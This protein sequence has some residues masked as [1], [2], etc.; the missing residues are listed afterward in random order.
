[1]EQRLAL[2]GNVALAGAAI[3]LIASA[4]LGLWALVSERRGR[5]GQGAWP[6]WLH[7][8]AW[9]L[10]SAAMGLLIGLFLTDA[11]AFAYVAGR[12]SRALATVYKVAALWAGQEG[13]LVLWLWLQ[14]GYGLVVAWRAHEGRTLD[15]GAA[16][17][18]AAISAFFAVLVAWVL[19][20]F[21]LRL[22]APADGA[23]M[24]PILQ[25]YWMTS[26]PVMLYLGYVG[27]SVPFAYALSSLVTGDRAWIRI[28]R[29]WSLV[30]WAFLS[31]GILYGARWAYEVLGWG[32]YWGWDPVE[33]ASF[34]PWLAATAFI[35]SGI[36][37]EKRGMLRRWNYVLV[38]VTYLLTVFGT[39]VTR[40][41][42]LSSVHAFV[43]SD[44]SPWFIG[45]MGVFIAAFLYAIIA[46]WPELADERPIVSPLSKESSFLAGNV[47]LLATCFAIFWGTIFPLVAAAFGRQV[48]VGTPY[49]E[50]VTGPLFWALIVLMGVGPLIAWRKATAENLKRQF[51]APLVNAFFMLI[52]LLVIGVRELPV[53]MALPAVMFVAITIVME[54]AKGVSTRRKS[55][56]EP[57]LV[58]LVR[59]MNRSPGRYG[60]Y[61]VHFGVLM[62]V[63]GVAL[64]QV[65]Q[66]ETNAVLQVGEQVAIGPYRLSLFHVDEA[67]HGGVPAVEAT[68]LVR[69]QRSRPLGYILPSK[70]FYPTADPG[71]GPTT[72]AAIYGTWKGD[73]YAVLAG[74]EPYGTYVGLKLYYSPGVWLIWTGGGLLV[75]GTLFSLWPRRRA[76]QVSEEERAVASLAELELD[77][78]A[79]KVSEAEYRA[80]FAEL[81]PKARAQLE[82]EKQ[83][84]ERVLAELRMRVA[85]AE[86]DGG[87]GSNAGE[88]DRARGKIRSGNEEAGDGKD[89]PAGR[90]RRGGYGRASSAGKGV[91]A[92]TES[93][94]GTAQG[95]R[96]GTGTETG[97]ESGA[98]RG[99]APGTGTGTGTGLIALALAA[100]LAAFSLGDVAFA[101]EQVPPGTSA[102]G[103]DTEGSIRSAI[104]GDQAAA[105]GGA[106]AGDEV[107]ESGG[108]PVISRETLVLRWQDEL[109]WVLDLVTITN[110]GDAAVPQVQLPLA[111]GASEVAFGDEALELS[112]GSAWDRRPLAPGELRRYTLQY[113]LEV[114]RW[115]HPLQREIVY[116]TVELYV[117]AVPGELVAGGLD[118]EQ[119]P[120]EL[121]AGQALDVWASHLI[122]PGTLWQVIVRPG[123][124]AGPVVGWNP[125]LLGLPVLGVLDRFPGD[126]L[127][128]WY[129]RQPQ[130]A[131]AAL[132]LV[133]LLVGAMV[134]YYLWWKRR[135]H[136]GKELAGGADLAGRVRA[137]ARLDVA[138][139]Q[140]AIGEGAYQRRR[141]RLMRRLVRQVQQA[142]LDRLE[143]L[144]GQ[145]GGK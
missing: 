112:D 142:D 66:V 14:S 101:A 78:Q 11:F 38:F 74:W 119:G 59:M 82:S 70:R 2:L 69:D 68:L 143:K 83:A 103:P 64:S 1:M 127:V 29:R 58:A 30:A 80:L 110:V 42:I 88:S 43:E 20:P 75:F 52:W 40:S 95:P 93:E 130:S 139:A 22:P 48:T 140:G 17:I 115:P 32:G 122:A 121:V 137:V 98:G 67:D 61:V 111:P 13:S 50:R 84:V 135:E 63:V 79:G 102:V 8:A 49:F 85:G 62:I 56:K 25:S 129:M 23:G 90:G 15:R 91:G 87:T 24:N 7:A 81:S 21:A 57:W 45:Y 113:A 138:Y 65:Y 109:L 107:G 36:I 10:V 60:G 51:T 126:W 117:M 37:E 72:Q 27:F 105:R 6:L 28:T 89:A 136:G 44:I 46:R 41:G 99:T 104:G 5:K 125:D 54:F 100:A 76:A 116:P 77:Y 145:Y 123:N 34:M 18:L 71:Q 134:G 97:T 12:S 128:Q 53:L 141:R 33:N 92:G 47:V 3:L 131:A 114:T 96:T 19:D 39:F 55:R 144:L 120:V 26:H 132:G 9:A 16:A 133:A 31:I 118:L 108:S 124:L 73:L 106:G 4:L 86:K 94:T 35:H